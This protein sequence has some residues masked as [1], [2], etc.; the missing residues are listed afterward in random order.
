[1]TGAGGR[2][3]LGLIFAGYV[4]LASQSLY[5]IIVYSV[6][7]YRP[8]LS[9]FWANMLFSR[10]QL[11]HFLFLCIDPFFKWNEEHF[12][13]HL[14]YQPCYSLYTAVFIVK[15][16]SP[17]QPGSE[18]VKYTRKQWHC[19]SSNTLTELGWNAP[20]EHAGETQQLFRMS[21]MLHPPGCLPS[22]WSM[23]T[24]ILIRLLTVNMKNFLTP[25]N[26]KMCDPI[27]VNSIVKMPPYPAAHPH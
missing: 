21:Y 22:K 5:P 8:Y 7:N 20:L 27:I 24:N 14:Q 15:P 4:P 10:S 3:V 23:H 1:M 26:P 9:H 2:G 16:N 17:V 18:S 12:I 19:N 6:A 11:N 13:F 25:K